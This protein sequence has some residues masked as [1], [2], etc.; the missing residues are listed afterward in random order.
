M[1]AQMA[2]SEGAL[3]GEGT[4]GRAMGGCCAAGS[5][6]LH[7]SATLEYSAR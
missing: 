5:V 4:H 6:R 1:L 7:C 2:V 3:R